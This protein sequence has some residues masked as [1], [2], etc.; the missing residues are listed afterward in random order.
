MHKFQVGDKVIVRKPD[1]RR[2]KVGWVDSCDKY[3]GKSARIVK[4]WKELGCV[5][6]DIDEKCVFSTHWIEPVNEEIL[7]ED[8]DLLDFISEYRKG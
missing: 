7:L 3:V 2:E 8:D 5:R 6:L 1:V 4:I